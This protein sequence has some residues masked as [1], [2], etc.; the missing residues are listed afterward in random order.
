MRLPGSQDPLGLARNGYR[1]EAM[2]G[3]K[4]KVELELNV[5]HLQLLDEMTRVYK[6]PGRDKALRCLLDYAMA[7]GDRDLIFGEIRCLHC[8]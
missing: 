7:E 8:G 2:G 3:D 4:T 6:L 5:L 1:R